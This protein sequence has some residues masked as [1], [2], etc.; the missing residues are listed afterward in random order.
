[1]PRY[2]VERTFPGGLSVPDDADGAALCL[3]VVERNNDDW[4]TWIHSY[5]SADRT[6]SFCVYDAPSPEA[7]RKTALRNELPV[8]RITQV[9]VL[10]PYFY[11]LRSTGPG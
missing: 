7:I 5:V 8:D 2:V 4:V 9:R 3:E 10:D 1:M 11:R 6:K